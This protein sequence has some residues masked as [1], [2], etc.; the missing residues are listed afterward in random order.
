M[1]PELRERMVSEKDIF[2]QLNGIR[3][4]YISIWRVNNIKILYT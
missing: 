2:I 3:K 4:G 1:E